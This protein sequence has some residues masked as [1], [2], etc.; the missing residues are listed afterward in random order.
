M[1]NEIKLFIFVLLFVVI[2]GTI[3][4]NTVDEEANTAFNNMYG[5]E[6]VGR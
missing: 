4:A 6:T 5:V 1:R 3:R 2:V